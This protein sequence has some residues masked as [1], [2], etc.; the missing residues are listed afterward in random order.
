MTVGNS[1]VEKERST[2]SIFF[3]KKVARAGEQTRDL[4]ISFI[5]S[6]PSLHC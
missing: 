6:I 4:V 5:F 2:M 1:D 3:K